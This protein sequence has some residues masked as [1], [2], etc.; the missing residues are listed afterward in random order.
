MLLANTDALTNSFNRRRLFEIGEE[1]FNIYKKH[2]H[3]FSLMILDI[4][5]FKRINDT[6]G[7]PVGD[8]VL[9][10]VSNLIE[11]SIRREDLLCRYGGEEF[12]IL[13]KNLEGSK[14]ETIEAIKDRIG[15]HSFVIS[16]D[17]VIEL[18]ISA[19]VV[20]SSDEIT[21]FDDLVKKA[22]ALLYMAK[23]SGRNRIQYYSEQN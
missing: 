17:I 21:D 12:A 18:T 7:H 22:D 9:R 4:D 16:D 20:S 2:N 11:K 23:Q 10:E 14:R 5:H 8:E 3:G 19:G 15:K 13:F 1:L 6:Y